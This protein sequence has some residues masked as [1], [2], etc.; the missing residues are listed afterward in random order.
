MNT[1]ALCLAAWDLA[2]RG[3]RDLFAW[4]A[5]QGINTIYLAS[6]YHAG[7]FLHPHA[8]TRKVLL[9]E[10]GV[11]YFHPSPDQYRDTPLRPQ[12]A[13][14]ALKHD[15]VAEARLC[16]SQL[17][18][19]LYLWTVCLHNT[20]LGQLHPQLACRNAFGDVYPHALCPA[21]P[22]VA[23]YVRALIRDQNA[24][25]APDGFFLEATQYRGRSH[26]HHHER[27]GLPLPDLERRL[28]DLSFSDADVSGASEA[29]IDVESLRDCAREHLADFF[30][31]GRRSVTTLDAFRAAHPDLARY[32]AWQA[33]V[34]ESLISRI[35]TDC[36]ASSSARPVLLG[37]QHREL[38]QIFVGLYNQPAHRVEDIVR[39]ERAACRREQKFIAGVRLGF[40]FPPATPAVN[41]QA[42][43]C[44]IAR[45]VAHANIEG[46][47]FYMYGEAPADS[48]Q[49]IAPAIDAARTRKIPLAQR[50]NS[51]T[52]QAL[53][54][55]VGLIGAGMAGTCHLS[56]LSRMAGVEPI[57]VADIKLEKARRA[58]DLVQAELA[59]TD[60]N[61]LIDR[62]DVDLIVVATPPRQHRDLALRVLDCGKHL[63]LEKPFG[64]NARETEDIFRAAR[65]SSAKGVF[66]GALVQRYN[67]T[68]FAVREMIRA[69]A[70]GNVNLVRHRFGVNMYGD[71]RFTRPAQE[72][73]GWL[74]DPVQA[75]GGLLPSASI[76][77]L[78]TINFMLGNPA[79]ETV[80]ATLRELHPNA[81]AGIED[82][83]NLSIAIAGGIELQF[84][85]SWAVD[86]PFET[87]IH[88]DR[89]W[90]VIS[91]PN[92][93]DLTLSGQSFSE[94]F[95]RRP[96]PGVLAR[97]VSGN[98][99]DA[100][101]HELDELTLGTFQGLACDV[102]R[103]CHG[104]SVETLP[105]I[106]HALNMRN[107]I[108]AA[109]RSSAEKRVEKIAW[110]SSRTFKPVRQRESEREQ[111]E[112]AV[113]SERR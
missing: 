80:R 21:H 43:A 25:Y 36:L 46:M 78:S 38:D 88:G 67:G 45:E 63:L 51:R 49:W 24:R 93:E 19:K 94:A 32:E 87:S 92:Y 102:V 64:M 71:P 75:G 57:G 2:D 59:T 70:I 27:D 82:H 69:G 77:A 111:R 100:R 33:D 26:G 30:A 108:D 22:Q 53:P 17:N 86:Q 97:F 98:R 112:Q 62:A 13:T 95:C 56:M 29:G 101:P 72:E 44:E 5:D 55:R 91:G 89:G 84:E 107:V 54:L 109:A 66:A 39:S 40:N 90:L 74:T 52:P 4:A 61:E 50:G 18:L 105:D 31:T 68:R 73:R 8:R 20:R 76:H 41:S 60:P 96:S 47:A 85:D 81:I 42:Q 1:F 99:I 110:V 7:W 48:L 65:R 106:E 15:W 37:S 28:M 16:A 12:V 14:V 104:E 83:A 113:L 79:F 103:A 9:A 10:E 3:T 58:A 34:C 11:C 6:E 23:E 35:R